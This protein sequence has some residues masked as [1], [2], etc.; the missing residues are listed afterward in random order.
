MWHVCTKVGKSYF[1]Q[2]CRTVCSACVGLTCLEGALQSPQLLELSGVGSRTRLERLGIEVIVDLP[3]VGE[4][5]QDHPVTLSDF[6][7]KKGI[8][9]LGDYLLNAE[10]DRDLILVRT[11][12]GLA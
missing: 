1:Q 12:T 9:T 5:L 11:Q 3:E 6:A 8:E 10:N 4:N 2:V 7:I